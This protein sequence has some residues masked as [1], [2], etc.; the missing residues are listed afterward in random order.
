MEKRR[1]HRGEAVKS[2]LNV[3]RMP[4]GAPHCDEVHRYC[5]VAFGDW[6]AG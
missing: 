4:I 2:C 1:D 3:K 6:R 5:A